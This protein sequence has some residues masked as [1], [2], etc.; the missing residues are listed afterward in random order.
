M[1]TI[2]IH[3]Q[4]FFLLSLSGLASAQTFAEAMENCKAFYRDQDYYCATIKTTLYVKDSDIKPKYSIMGS[5]AKKA[6]EFRIDVGARTL[7]T[8][9]RCLL[10]VDAENKII[11]YSAPQKQNKQLDELMKEFS[12]PDSLMR[13]GVTV[14]KVNAGEDKISFEVFPKKHNPS[15]A[16]PYKTIITLNKAGCSLSSIVYLFK[17]HPMAPYERIVIKYSHKMGKESVANK[18]F[19]ENMYVTGNGSK[20]TPTPAY[21]G[22]KIVIQPKTTSQIY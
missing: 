4:L 3:I 8:N 1:K 19:S 15:T 7:I 11:A 6:K 21:T 5:F 16:E 18:N 14:S 2:A 20:I 10:V 22:Y 13:A 12:N 17:P 9:S